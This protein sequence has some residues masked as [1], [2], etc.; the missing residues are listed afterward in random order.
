MSPEPG[1][2]FSTGTGVSEIQ[3]RQMV[4]QQGTNVAVVGVRG[5]F[6]DS[7]T[8]VKKIF[9]DQ[10]T[11]EV[12]SRRGYRFSSANS[13]NWGRLAPQIVYYFS[14]YLDLIRREEIKEGEKINFVVPTGNFGNIL[15]GFYAGRAGLPV[16]RLICASNTNH[17]LTDFIQSGTYDRNRPFLRTISPSMDILISSNLE[18]LLFEV[19]GRQSNR[20]KQWMEQLAAEGRYHVNRTTFEQI[21]A[22]FWSG[23]STEQET[24]EAISQVYH[25]YRYV[26]DPHTAV[27]VTVL[28]ISAGNRGSTKL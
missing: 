13:I 12:L 7:Q 14:A 18:R 10:S 1:S 21:A 15:A 28:E 20:V 27:A 11:I 4:T 25:R 19:S 5:N 22:L 3:K 8:G 2:L 24:M 16:N 26:I 23:Y 17:V 6:D 9:T